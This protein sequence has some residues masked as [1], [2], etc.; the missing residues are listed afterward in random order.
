MRSLL[1]LA[2]PFML[3]GRAQVANIAVDV[4]FRPHL[5]R[6]NEI[7]TAYEIEGEDC[8]LVMRKLV[9]RK[10]GE[11]VLAKV[12]KAMPSF[13][14]QRVKMVSGRHLEI[15]TFFDPFFYSWIYVAKITSHKG[16]HLLALMVLNEEKMARDY[17][18]FMDN[19]KIL[20]V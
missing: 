11:K 19:L 7:A 12:A 9:N 15:G 17:F 4:H 8:Y 2:L 18:S 20:L 14:F 16:K 3:W 1:T 5:L 6:K 13:Q 10:E